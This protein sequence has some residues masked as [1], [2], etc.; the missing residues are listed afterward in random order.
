MMRALLLAALGLTGASMLPAQGVLAGRI[1]GTTYFAPSGSYKIA[2]PVLSELGGKVV[3]TPDVVTFEDDFNTH[4][5]IA[6]FKMDATQRWEF[7]TR[8]RKEYLIWFFTEYVQRDFQER[9]PG[10]RVESAKYIPSMESGTLLTYNLLPGGTMFR[11][12]PSY[13]E[14]NEPLVAKRGNLTLMRDG[15]VYV[16]SIELAERAVQRLSYNKTVAEEDELLR[17]RLLE[18]FARMTFIG[19][20]NSGK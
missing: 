18:L 9:F 12:R 10:S 1:E 11:N 5:S 2:I 4:A 7:E 14:T 20:A 19:P 3:D 15:F 17:K 6:C 8:G 13:T 16:L